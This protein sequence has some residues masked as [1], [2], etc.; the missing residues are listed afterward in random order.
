[1][2]RSL[3]DPVPTEEEPLDPATYDV[4]DFAGGVRPG[5]RRVEV[6][7]RPDLYPDLQRVVA[8][9]NAVGDDADVDDL[10][11]EYERIR[12]QMLVE[13]I[14]ERRSPEWVKL[15]YAETATEMGITAKNGATDVVRGDFTY[16]QAVEVSMRMILAQTVSPTDWDLER[17]RSLFKAAPEQVDA[18]AD[19]VAQVNAGHSEALT[20]DF[21]QR[22]STKRGTRRSSTS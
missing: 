14:V 1:M 18:L 6:Q 13:W 16:E 22:R 12:G 2:E 15:F 20:L 21:S 17:L 9:I 8:K 11:D 19:A 10:I 7:P 4:T 5:R 3:G